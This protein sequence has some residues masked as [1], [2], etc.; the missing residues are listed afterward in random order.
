MILAALVGF[1]AELIPVFPR[2]DTAAI[3]LIVRATKGARSAPL[4]RPGI[5]LNDAD[6]PS[7]A[8]EAVLRDAAALD[9]A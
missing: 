3:R 9:P 8:A 7:A 4:S 6:R 5:V 1:A 2:P